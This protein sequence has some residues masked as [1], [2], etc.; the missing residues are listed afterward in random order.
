MQRARQLET[1]PV[2]ITLKGMRRLLLI[3]GIHPSGY[4]HDAGACGMETARQSGPQ[5]PHFLSS[6]TG[7]AGVNG[8]YSGRLVTVVGCGGTMGGLAGI[9]GVS[10]A[11]GYGGSRQS[12]A[13]DEAESILSF[14]AAVAGSACRF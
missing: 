12:P 14:A 4:R 3:R 9:G 10:Y 6:P 2:G 11:T 5:D 1:S 7:R 13:K 8:W